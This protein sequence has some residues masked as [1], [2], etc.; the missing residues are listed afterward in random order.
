FAALNEYDGKIQIV[1]KFSENEYVVEMEPPVI[2]GVTQH[3]L[4]NLKINWEKLKRQI[5]CSCKNE[6]NV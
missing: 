4:D 3:F 5:F 6:T 1:D 2:S